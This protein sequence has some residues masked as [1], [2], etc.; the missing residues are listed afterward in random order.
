MKTRA[1]VTPRVPESNNEG[2]ESN[3]EVDMVDSDTEEV[4]K[5]EDVDV[6]SEVPFMGQLMIKF[7]SHKVW[8]IRLRLV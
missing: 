2:D 4:C 5:E 1:T 6:N 7:D 8:A 3:D